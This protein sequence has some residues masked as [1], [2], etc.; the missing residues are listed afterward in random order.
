MAFAVF[1]LIFSFPE[2]SLE[3]VLLRLLQF[4]GHFRNKSF[5]HSHPCLPLHAPL[6]THGVN[7]DPPTWL[8][9]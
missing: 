1:K 3:S 4:R 7:L 5:E 8:Q 9:F 6:D 2:N